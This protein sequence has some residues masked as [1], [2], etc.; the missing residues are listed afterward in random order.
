MNPMLA[1]LLLE[2]EQKGMTLL[3]DS[4]TVVAK[5]VIDGKDIGEAFT[6]LGM[7]LAEKQAK[8]IDDVLSPK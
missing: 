2:A 3:I 4:L 8:A 5:A 7:V 6:E 1:G